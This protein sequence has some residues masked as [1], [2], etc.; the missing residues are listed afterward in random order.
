MYSTDSRVIQDVRVVKPRA[1]M[2]KE[3]EAVTAALA[4]QMESTERDAEQVISDA[5]QQ[6]WSLV[7]RPKVGERVVGGGFLGVFKKMHSD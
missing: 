1:S 2:K 6:K 3:P 4:S 5:E 7:C